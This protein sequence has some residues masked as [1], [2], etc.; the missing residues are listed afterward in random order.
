[1]PGLSGPIF[2]LLGAL[3]AAGPGGDA[4]AGEAQPQDRPNQLQAV[5]FAPL[6]AGGALVRLIFARQAQSPPSVLVNHHPI[7]RITF[8]FPDTVAASG[9]QLIEVGPGGLRTIQVV[10][11]GSRTRVILNIDRP[12]SFDTILRGTILLITLRRQSWDIAALTSAFTSTSRRRP[13]P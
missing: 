10:P 13:A 12:F 6:P 5:D 3:L 1:M 2:V 9:R 7:R 4:S 8:D 11:S